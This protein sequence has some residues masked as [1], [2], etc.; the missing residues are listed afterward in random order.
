MYS[1]PYNVRELEKRLSRLLRF[2]KQT[3]LK[4]AIFRKQSHQLK[5]SQSPILM[6]LQIEKRN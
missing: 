3:A 1:W 6:F 4:R 2:V 5:Q